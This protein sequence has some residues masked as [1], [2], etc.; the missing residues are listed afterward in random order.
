MVMVQK[1]DSLHAQLDRRIE[2]FAGN[3]VSLSLRE[4]VDYLRQK[5][6]TRTLRRVYMVAA[7]LGFRSV[8]SFMRSAD[9]I[10]WVAAM[11][12]RPRPWSGPI[13]LFRASVQPEPRLPLDL[14]WTPLAEGGVELYELPGDHDLVFREPNI[15]VLAAQL[16]ARLERSD[17]AEVR[18]DEPAAFAK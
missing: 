13:T 2:R 6:F 16:R 3:F 9:E 12:Y 4:K 15:H 1:K 10:S 17:A 8:P 5:L 18:L 7:A 11:N 14:G